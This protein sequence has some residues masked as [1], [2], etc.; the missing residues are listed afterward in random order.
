MSE[1]VKACGLGTL[2]GIALFF[3]LALTGHIDRW[4]AYLVR[5]SGRREL[6]KVS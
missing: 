3:V 4:T 1:M 6:K 5:K 2:I